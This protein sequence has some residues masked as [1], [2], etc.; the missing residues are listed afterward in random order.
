[1]VIK[2]SGKI[3]YESDNLHR[4]TNA[5]NLLEY[6]ED[7]SRSVGKNSFWYLDTDGTTAD[8][9]A[10]FEARRVLT[11]AAQNN[12]GGGAKSINE[13]IPL[14][15]FTFFEELE[16]NMLPPM[17]LTIELTLNDDAELIHMANGTDEGRVVVKRLYLWLPK[18][19]PKDSLYSKFV[20]DFH[21]PTTWPYMRDLYNQSANTR[22]TQ[23]MFQI[24]PAID[25]VKHV[26]VYLQR[27][28]GP[29]NAESERT[30]Y[31]HL[32]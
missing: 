22:A 18:L 20:S 3:V 11:Q 26:F 21:K 15:R 14:N 23:N 6:S 30:P 13:M 28:D 29:N 4:I 17:Q 25:G 1:M 31:M 10:G 8:T 2:S 12:G 32:R 19:L 24:S 16:D 5:K 27:T 7:F 9:N